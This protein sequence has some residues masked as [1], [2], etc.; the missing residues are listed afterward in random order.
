MHLNLYYQPI[1]S[2]NVSTRSFFEDSNPVKKVKK[3]RKLYSCPLSLY[4]HSEEWGL[5][6]EKHSTRLFF[7]Y[8]FP[9]PATNHNQFL[10]YTIPYMYTRI[11]P[12]IK[13]KEG[14]LMLYEPRTHLKECP[15]QRLW[16][17]ISSIHSTRE[18]LEIYWKVKWKYLGLARG[19]CYIVTLLSHTGV[20]TL[21]RGISV[22]QGKSFP[23]RTFLRKQKNSIQKSSWKWHSFDKKKI[24]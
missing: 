6:T 13:M 3:E 8:H 18:A 7:L 10:A 23:P 5:R 22:G 12:C 16:N 14:K 2:S 15:N 1:N 20:S 9:L 17:C 24:E 21:Y 4:H 11:Y 19:V